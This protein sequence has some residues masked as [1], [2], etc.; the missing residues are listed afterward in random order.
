MPWKEYV[1]TGGTVKKS[2]VTILFLSA[3]FTRTFAT[4]VAI[5]D[6]SKAIYLKLMDNAI[7]VDV[8][9]QVA[10]VTTTQTFKNYFN[11]AKKVKY[12]F[13]MPENGSAIQL[14]FYVNGHWYTAKFSASPQDTTLPHSGEQ[15]D[16]NLREYLGD[17]PLFYN[18]EYEVPA[19][20][21]LIVRLKYVQLLT[22]KF[23]NVHFTY[24]GDYRLLQTAPVDKQSFDFFLNSDRTINE[25]RFVDLQA[26][27]TFNDGHHAELHFSI[28][29]QVPKYDF[30]IRYQLAANELGLFSMSTFLPDSTVPDKGVPGFFT[31]VAEPDP[32]ENASVI[33]KVFTLIVD[34]S[35]SMSGSKIEQARDAAKFI[36]NN[37]NEGDKFNIIDFANQASS[38]RDTH[39]E[40]N[41]ANRDSALDYIDGFIAYGG[42][43]IT[44]A[45]DLAIP[46]FKDSDDST[47]NIII[48]FTDGLPT[49]GITDISEL[50]YHINQ[51][52]EQNHVKVSIFDFGI[53]DDANKQFLASLAKE[54]N[55]TADFLGDEE[56]ESQITNFYLTIRNPVLLN[57]Q[58]AFAPAGLIR[59]VYP[60]SLPNL[61][62]GQQLIASGRYSEPADVSVTLRGTAFGKAV[63]YTYSLHLSDSTARKY[64][65]LT[66]IW[67]KQKIEDLLLEYYSYDENST[68]AALL[69]EEII[70][71]SM[72]FGV[73]SPFT[74]FSGATG[75]ENREIIKATAHHPQQ[76]EL[77]ANYPNPFN[78]ST[79]IRFR[80]N[81][82]W[83]GLVLIKIYDSQGKLVR[84]LALQVNQSGLYRVV[85]DGRLNN[86]Q[87]A[88]SGTYVYIVNF[89]NEA[90][91]AGKMIL[92]K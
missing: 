68:E 40:Y 85:W 22:Y 3:I 67:A 47:A 12:A 38:F 37:L 83:H 50:L 53:G 11:S 5:V 75:M 26:D 9:N 80:I 61:Y 16:A 48:F 45:F 2:I 36:V 15:I 32:S 92:I 72:N 46:Q 76:F 52:I 29:E 6:I 57:T 34:R 90:V 19:G 62:K 18:I 70:G 77:L 20:G 7:R 28:Y 55:G 59:E 73:L 89:G 8:D 74:S 35:G 69:K 10:I 4:G 81:F 30:R 71:I 86:G 27:S 65:F 17:T 78:P 60:Q 58:I 31:F 1:I 79:T 21:N 14:D 13:P 51:L 44:Q 84:V 54:H 87:P 24:K 42:T 43:N 64:Q 23:G 66:K 82:P 91:L 63:E 39:V 56:L 33:K 25:L 41:Q 88:A 49:F